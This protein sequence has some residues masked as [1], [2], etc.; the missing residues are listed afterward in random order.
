MLD[1]AA[2]RLLRL[3]HAF[4]HMPER[5]LLRDRRGDRG[6]L[7]QAGSKPCSS[8]AVHHPLGRLRR[9][10]RRDVDQH[11]PGM[12]RFQRIAHAVDMLGGELDAEPRH[13]FEAGQRRA[14]E[15]CGQVEKRE[16][17]FDRVEAREGD[18]MAERLREKLQ[19]RA[20]DDAERA[21]G[22]DEEVAQVV[23]GI[24][25][26]QPAQPVPDLA[27]RQHDFE[28]EA[29]LAHVAIGKHRRA[30][31][32]G[33]EIA[34]DPAGAFRAERQRK[35]PAMRFGRLLD[36]GKNAA[37]IGDDHVCHRIDVADP[38]HPFERQDDIGLALARRL[39]ADKAG[40]A[41]LRHDRGAG[42][43][44]KLQDCRDFLDVGG[45]Q[46]QRRGAM[47][48]P[49][50]LDQVRRKLGLA[51]QRIFVADDGG[52]AVEKFR[53]DAGAHR[54]HSFLVTRAARQRASAG[55]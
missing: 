10:R 40:I 26:L 31:G 5:L 27:R 22:A 16:R 25:L 8:S 34:A 9:I 19:H 52:E 48:E 4:A 13:Q 21:F 37:A 11:I 7:D 20:G 28:A 12:R 49:A 6:V 2:F 35:Q 39:A 14:A 47:I 1:R 54:A 24:V 55:R 51:A 18:L 41:G 42:F 3:R 38:V 45:L 33:R 17:I 32:I 46:Q 15:A 50:V 23:A 29:E 43:A 30:A 53:G 36:L 44:G